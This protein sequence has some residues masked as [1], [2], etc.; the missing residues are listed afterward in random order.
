MI[1]WKTLD[2]TNIQTYGFELELID[3]VTFNPTTET[4]ITK[5]FDTGVFFVEGS[6][7]ATPENNLMVMV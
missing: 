7:Q 1:V 3:D 2:V 4:V 5:S 6:A